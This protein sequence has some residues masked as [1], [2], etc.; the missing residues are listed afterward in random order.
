MRQIKLEM[1]GEIALSPKP[2]E[3][4]K[5]WRDIFEIS[6][7]ELARHMKVSV[8]TISD[9]EGGRRK[10]PG[11]GVINRF[12]NALFEIDALK[13]G[14]V[15]QKFVEKEKTPEDFFETHEF[16][17]SMPLADFVNLIKGEIITNADVI[18][19]KKIYGYTLI[20]SIKVILDMPFSY[21]QNL[22]GNVNERAF[23]FLGVSTG[24]SPMVVL[25]VS[26]SK[27]SAVVFH[28]IERTK[29]DKL[30]LKIS[31]KEQIPVIITKMAVSDIKKVLTKL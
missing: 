25:R 13:G 17:R 27:P 9:Y 31:E 19:N 20:D 22:Y 12:V 29:L 11:A 30:A 4:M 24:R 23:I 21:F 1:A 18:E 28:N 15:T 26:P 3:T 2:G 7:V 16:A 10:S 5:K 8:S 14:K 6:Q